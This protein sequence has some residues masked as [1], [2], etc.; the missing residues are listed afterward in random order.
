MKRSVLGLDRF[1]ILLLGLVLLVSGVAVGAWGLGYLSTVWSG[2][3]DELST[4]PA[5]DVLSASWWGWAALA[6]GVVLGLL[7]VWWLVAHRTH[8]SI[9]PLRLPGTGSQGRLTLDGSA[10]ADVAADVI[11]RTRGVHSAKGKTIADRGQLV[12]DL[13]V[14]VEPDADL[15]GVAE[16]TDAAMADLAV[17]LGR[18][19]VRSRVTLDV[20]RSARQQSRVS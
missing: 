5:T 16:A 13:H 15:R 12:A 20:A 11:A 1:L 6:G 2:A 17:V 19:D 8:H 7:A 14:T 18:S 3:P 9:G 4:T 10:A